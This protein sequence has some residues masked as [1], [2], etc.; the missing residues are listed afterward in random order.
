MALSFFNAMLC[1]FIFN[2]NLHSDYQLNSKDIGRYVYKNSR[3][4][5]NSPKIRHT[6]ILKYFF[7]CWFIIISDFS[8]LVLCISSAKH[9]SNVGNIYSLPNAKIFVIN[10]I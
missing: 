5:N 2:L 8:D 3:K 9:V 7:I 6:N 10:I 4:L 1:Y